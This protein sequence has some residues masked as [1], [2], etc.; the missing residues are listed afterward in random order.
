VVLHAAFD[1][2]LS[3]DKT[4]SSMPIES[5]SSISHPMAL[6]HKDLGLGMKP[7]LAAPP[8]RRL[9]MAHCQGNS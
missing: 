3:V 8:T 1:V 9:S 2:Y 4:I 5:K 6:T 7:Y